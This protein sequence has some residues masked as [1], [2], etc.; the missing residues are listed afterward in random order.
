MVDYEYDELGRV[1][2]RKIDE[3][4][5]NANNVSTESTPWAG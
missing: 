4:T 3:A 2:G 5:T 1:T